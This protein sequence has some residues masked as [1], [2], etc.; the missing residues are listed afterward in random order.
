MIRK[1]LNAYLTP[2]APPATEK[3]KP[4]KKPTRPTLKEL[5]RVASVDAELEWE[6]SINAGSEP[7]RWL[8]RTSGWLDRR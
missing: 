2:P 8:P 1:L 3:T 7:R 5:E 6:R 4:K